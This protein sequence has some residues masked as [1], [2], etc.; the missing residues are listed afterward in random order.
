MPNPERS[1]RTATNIATARPELSLFL[2]ILKLFTL[3][4]LLTFLALLASTPAA[5]VSFDEQE[6]QELIADYNGRA[7]AEQFGLEILP[8]LVRLYRAGDTQERARIAAIFYQLGWQSEEAK[9]V[10][11]NDLDT[12]DETLRI[13]VQYAL[14]RVSND[15]VVVERLLETVQ[16]GDTPLIRDKAACGLAHDQIHLT[17]PQKVRLFRGLIDL[18]ESPVKETRSLAIRVLHVHTGQAKGYSAHLP[19][20]HRAPGVARWKLWI[21]EYE[22]NL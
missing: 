5:A 22:A 15:D 17:E 13:R 2:A 19:V 8:E 10:L 20:E 3:F 11:L 21:D 9:A 14:G 1:A 4:T 18:L 16:H 7:I 12:P 6:L